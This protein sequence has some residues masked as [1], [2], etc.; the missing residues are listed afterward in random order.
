MS[1]VFQNRV[2]AGRQLAWALERYAQHDDVV[3]LA[4]PRGGVPVGYEVARALRCPLDVLIVRKLGA[5]QNREL[6]M[7]AIAS[8][9]ALYV[10]NAVLRALDVSEAQFA[11]T[12][13]RER[14]EL[15]RRES[16]YR[17]Q[18]PPAAVQGKTVIVVDDGMATGAT[19]HAAL[20]ALR[21]R[22]PRALVVAVPVCPAGAERRF[23]GVADDFVC[24]MQPHGFMGIG[25]FYADFAQT[26][27]EEVRACLDAAQGRQ[28]DTA[29]GAAGGDAGGAHS[30]P[31][32]GGPA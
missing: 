9:D 29:R 13:E 26:S 22:R 5:P 11:E 30:V 6:A 3:V 23:A 4:L 25:Q 32:S 19:M 28:P 17:G 1:D 31:P 2:D 20:K 14:V 21:A 15:H 27:D 12:F 8:G 16:A 10:N 18:R 24:V 7:G